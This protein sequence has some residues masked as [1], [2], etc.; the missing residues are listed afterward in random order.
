MTAAV[1]PTRCRFSCT[2]LVASSCDSVSE[3]GRRNDGVPALRNAAVLA[4]FGQR[5]GPHAATDIL[6]VFDNAFPSVVTGQAG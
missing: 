1:V 3:L 4:V 6:V 2:G 5:Q